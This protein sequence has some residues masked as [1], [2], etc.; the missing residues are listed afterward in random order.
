[1]VTA[2]EAMEQAH[3][4]EA[5]KPAGGTPSA[6]PN[7]PKPDGG[8]VTAAPAPAPT[9]AVVAPTLEEAQAIVAESE[10]NA[11]AG[12]IE[13]LREQN[14][15]LTLRLFPEESRPGIERVLDLQKDAVYIESE[16]AKIGAE[17]ATLARDRVV[18]EFKEFGVTADL[19]KHC[20]DEAAMKIM[21]ES[22]KTLGGKPAE[23]K[24]EGGNPAA[25]KEDPNPAPTGAAAQASSVEKFHGQG[26]EKGMAGLLSEVVYGQE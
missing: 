10:K 25:M 8:P 21:A 19:L 22:I 11:N 15:S 1:M 20:P 3:A 2:A 9:P 7:E 24:P 16:R 26:V 18:E 5:T 17:K 23:A 12:E 13:K 14:R 4:A 6:N